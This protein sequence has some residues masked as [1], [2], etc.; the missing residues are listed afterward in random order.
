MTA[1]TLLLSVAMAFSEEVVWALY[2]VWAVRV[3]DGG[4]RKRNENASAFSIRQ[5]ITRKNKLIRLTIDFSLE[6]TQRSMDAIVLLFRLL[7][8]K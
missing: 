4:R 8:G 2:P 3:D 5:I 6:G 1:T 7:V